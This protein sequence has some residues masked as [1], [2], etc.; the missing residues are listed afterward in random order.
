M[1]V[2][3]MSDLLRKSK[4]LRMVQKQLGHYSPT[5]TANMYAD[6]SFEDMQAGVDGL[7]ENENDNGGK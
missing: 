5:V 3:G 1:W 4:S 7:Y 2:G 6:I